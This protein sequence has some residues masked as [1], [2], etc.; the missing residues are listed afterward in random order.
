MEPD[1]FGY[2]RFSYLG[3]SDARFSRSTDQADHRIPIL[4]ST[5]RL[6]ERF[7]L[8]EKLCAPSLRRQTDKNFRLALFT[9]P[10]LPDPYKKRL[11][12]AIQDIP[13]IEIVYDSAPHINDAINNWNRQQHVLQSHRTVQFR[14]DDDDSLACD[15]IATLRKYMHHLPDYTIISRPLGLFLAGTPEGAEILAKFEPYIAIGFALV[16]PP[17]RGRNPY[18]LAHRKHY[19]T[20]PS[21]CLPDSLAYIH[22]AHIYSDTAAEHQRKLAIARADHA[23]YFSHRP[24]RFWQEI[25]RQFGGQGPQHFIDI[26]KNTPA[27]RQSDPENP[28]DGWRRE[29]PQD[30][31]SMAD[32]VIS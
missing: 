29:D 2:M 31:A 3:R 1:I 22:S 19:R 26:M 5:D 20:V 16:N 15:F 11:S 28:A 12:L 32:R 9:S 23:R 14:L 17:G 8:F 21:L 18:D 6:E 4:Y 13:Q 27:Q 24:K 10:E 7:Y 25:K 30:L